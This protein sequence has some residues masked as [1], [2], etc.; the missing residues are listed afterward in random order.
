MRYMFRAEWT[1]TLYMLYLTSGYGLLSQRGRYVCETFE[2]MD[3]EVRRYKVGRLL[4][5]QLLFAIVINTYI[6]HFNS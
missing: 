2:E 6:T 3:Q 4:L 1:Q 5:L